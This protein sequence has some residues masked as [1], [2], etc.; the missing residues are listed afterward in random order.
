MVEDTAIQ[1]FPELEIENYKEGTVRPHW[2]PRVWMPQDRDW[3]W[4]KN[5]IPQN[6]SIDRNQGGEGGFCTFPS[7]KE[8]HL[9]SLS[10]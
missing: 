10:N 9:I 5:Q 2:R 7:L 8:F 3:K 6:C 1:I 4:I